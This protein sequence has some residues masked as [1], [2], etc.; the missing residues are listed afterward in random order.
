M[1]RGGGQELLEHAA[2]PALVQGKRRRSG[3]P[4]A[5][6]NAH[7]AGADG[8][9]IS[10]VPHQVA[11]AVRVLSGAQAVGMAPRPDTPK[12]VRVQFVAQAAEERVIADR[13]IA[14]LQRYPRHAQLAGAFQKVPDRHGPRRSLLQAG[15]DVAEI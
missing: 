8:L 9:S 5:A 4:A 7:D 6:D 15:I 14:R 13:E 10:K 3:P 1:I 11:R 2:Q 12:T